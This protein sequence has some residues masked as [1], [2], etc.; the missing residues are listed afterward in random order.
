MRSIYLTIIL[1]SIASSLRCPSGWRRYQS[2][3]YRY[4]LQRMRFWPGSDYC[5]QQVFY[6]AH[7]TKPIN[8]ELV[9]IH[10]PAENAFVFSIVPSGI[11]VQLG[12]YNNVNHRERTWHWTDGSPF[13]YSNWAPGQ[14]DSSIQHYGSMWNSNFPSQ[15]DDVDRQSLNFVCKVPADDCL[16]SPYESSTECK[17]GGKFSDDRVCICPSPYSCIDCSWYNGC[18]SNPC[19]NGGQCINNERSYSC[20][21]DD[22]FTGTHCEIYEGCLAFPCMNRG[23]CSKDL[24]KEIFVCTCPEDYSG[25]TCQTYIG[26]CKEDPCEN[27]GTCHSI[28]VA[29]FYICQC[30]PP[31]IGMTCGATSNGYLSN[32]CLN[33]STCVTN[34]ETNETSCLCSSDHSG[35]NCGLQKLT[36]KADNQ[37]S[38]SNTNLIVGFIVV[39][40]SLTAIILLLIGYIY[41]NRRHKGADAESFIGLQNDLE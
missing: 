19:Q 38:Q 12:L 41:L 27:G 1:A 39:T 33:G 30:K 24:E 10:S 16:K 28:S 22:G 26:H 25:V 11:T 4:Y 7:S 31:Y 5:R 29:P 18:M 13:D 34:E 8:S 6:S 14:P 15:W 9:S 3:C 35:N 17:N 40:V 21:C 23:N 36:S 20:G 2:N 32:P 37:T